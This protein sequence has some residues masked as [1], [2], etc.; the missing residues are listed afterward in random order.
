MRIRIALFSGLIGLCV[1]GAFGAF[2]P[3]PRAG[4]PG[5][6]ATP[7]ELEAAAAILRESGHIEKATGETDWYFVRPLSFDT[8]EGVW[9]AAGVNFGGP[10]DAS[11]HWFIFQCEGQIWENT[12]SWTGVHTI[13]VQID[14]GAKS[15]RSLGVGASF[16]ETGVDPNTA[17]TPVEPPEF[18]RIRDG[19]TGQ[20]IRIER[21][22]IAR[23]PGHPNG[24]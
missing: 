18:I 16:S 8:D 15:V 10:V 5:R 23:C 14:L 1:I 20:L 22:D 3:E 17:P 7:A 13:H 19:R 2:E 24:N 4:G 11:G 21:S 6:A 12:S 9:F